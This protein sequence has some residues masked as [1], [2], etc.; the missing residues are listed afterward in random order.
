MFTK[1][2]LF[3]ITLQRYTTVGHRN[4]QSLLWN[5]SEPCDRGL[6]T[7]LTVKP[8]LKSSTWFIKRTN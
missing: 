2:Q 6:L 3:L 1:R 5:I 4:I 8:K 7:K